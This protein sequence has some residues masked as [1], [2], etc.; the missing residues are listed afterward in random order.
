MRKRGWTSRM[1]E[2]SGRAVIGVAVVAGVAV[3]LALLA[4]VVLVIAGI[5]HALIPYWPYVLAAFGVLVVLPMAVSLLLDTD[6]PSKRK[7]PSG[8]MTS[9]PSRP[10]ASGPSRA[11]TD[12]PFGPASWEGARP[13]ISRPGGTS[14]DWHS[15]TSY[16]CRRCGH[17]WTSHG[18]GQGS[19]WVEGPPYTTQTTIGWEDSIIQTE[20]GTP[21]G[22]SKYEGVEPR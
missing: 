20:S 5:V 10:V 22:C 8:P 16:S 1:D 7:A 4:C 12:E 6:R 9:G 14:I 13:V 2:A 11:L 18:N 3:L 19:C 17:N 21:C 15:A